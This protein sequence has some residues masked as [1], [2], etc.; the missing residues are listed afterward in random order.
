MIL[1][2]FRLLR[3]LVTFAIVGAVVVYGV[4]A[5]RVWQVAREDH[6]DRA[7]AIVVLGAA[8]FDGRPSRIFRAR[9]AHAKHLYDD[10]IAPRIVTIG[11]GQ[12]GDRTTEAAAGKQWLVDEGVADADVFA[13]AEGDDTVSS[14]QAADALLRARR[15]RSVVLVT[16]PWHSLR[17]RTIARDLG[18]RAT[19]SPARTGPAV[20]TRATQFRYILREAGAYLSYRVFGRVSG[21]PRAV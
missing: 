11:G 4:T 14:L 13:A 20:H 10:R 12:P 8:Q 1:R 3:R 9:L 21:G 17:S 19:T 6:R 18:L 15:W 5:L 16:D 2:P 7:D